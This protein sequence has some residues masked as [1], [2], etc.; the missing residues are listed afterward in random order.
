MRTRSLFDGF[1]YSPEADGKR[2]STLLDRV[3]VLM[4]DG[5]WRTLTEIVQAVGGTEASVSARLR[6]LR[7]S[8]FGGWEVQKRRIG[9]SGLYEY[10]VEIRSKCPEN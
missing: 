5:H 8:R 7:K 2:L 4:V 3:R 6:D 10:R 9:R 1:T